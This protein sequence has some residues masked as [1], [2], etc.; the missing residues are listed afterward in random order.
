MTKPRLSRGFVVSG[1]QKTLPW[2]WQE[3]LS[4]QSVLIVPFQNITVSV[5]NVTP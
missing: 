2:W 5:R 4:N 1:E 3:C